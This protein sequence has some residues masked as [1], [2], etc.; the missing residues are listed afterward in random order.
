MA[1]GRWGGVGTRAA[2]DIDWLSGDVGVCPL[3]PARNDRCP[4]DTAVAPRINIKAGRGARGSPSSPEPL[5]VGSLPV[6]PRLFLLAAPWRVHASLVPTTTPETGPQLARTISSRQFY[7]HLAAAYRMQRT[8]SGKHTYTPVPVRTQAQQQMQRCSL[9]SWRP[10]IHALPARSLTRPT[11]A[12]NS[13]RR[14]RGRL[15]PPIDNAARAR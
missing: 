12:A 14:N 4:P 13:H 9:P 11:M 7:K 3:L 5:S 6:S 8:P 15:Y 10:P 1:L 2:T